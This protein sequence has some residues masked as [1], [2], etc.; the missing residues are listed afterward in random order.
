M[1]EGFWLVALVAAAISQRP[2]AASQEMPKAIVALGDSTTAGTPGFKS[3]IES[4]PNGAGNAESQ[5]AY[6]LMQ[7]HADWRVLN[8]G[9]NGERS[10]EIRARFTRDVLDA[11]PAVVVII[12]GVNDVYQGRAADAVQREV[13]AM[14]GAARAAH[15]QV[16]AGTII[17]FNTATPDQNLRMHTVNAWIREYASRHEGVTFCDTRAAV[18]APG[19][20]DR[21]VSSPD[22]LHPSPEGYK[23]MAAAL[24]P[25]IK[26]AL[27]KAQ[28]L[29]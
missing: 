5:Y 23:L 22:G 4:P 12:A 3:P 2:P 9:V 11:I 8:R 16:V 15:I 25:A 24:E 29:R 18:S 19:Q 13:E 6:W 21:L 27:A 7:S 28:S 1:A 20:P 26:A 17:P 14:Y 10:D